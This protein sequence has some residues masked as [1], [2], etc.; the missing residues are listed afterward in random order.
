MSHPT[1]PLPATAFRP[2]DL[3]LGTDEGG[4]HSGE[5]SEHQSTRYA[6]KGEVLV[7][8]SGENYAAS[9]LGHI[10]PAELLRLWPAAAHTARLTEEGSR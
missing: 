3:V 6:D 9:S 10:A 2:G 7:Y 5:V 8:W 1:D 4:T